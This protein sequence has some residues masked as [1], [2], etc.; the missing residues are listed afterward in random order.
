MAK[1]R[2]PVPAATAAGVLFAADRTCCVC[3]EVGKPIQ[4][5][6]LDEDPT[7]HQ[8]ANLAVLCLAC[9]EDTQR[10]GGFSRR[11]DADQVRLYR[12]S[13]NQTVAAARSTSSASEAGEEA[14]STYDIA[15][16]I[17]L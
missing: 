15:Q 6:H 3:R 12:D 11:L 9:H 16:D 1:A 2:S 5:H 13:W 4:L 10:K 7:N 17:Q 8:Q 14:P